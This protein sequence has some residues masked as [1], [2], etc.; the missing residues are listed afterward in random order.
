MKVAVNEIDVCLESDCAPFKPRLTCK[1]GEQEGIF[2]VTLNVAAK[3]ESLLP[4]L[5]LTWD[6]PSVDFHHKWNTRCMQNRALDVGLGSY[7]HIQSSAN[8]GTPVF[9]LYSLNGTN[10]CTWA[11]SDVIHDTHTGGDYRSGKTFCCDM[12]V[13]GSAVGIVKD[14]AITVRFDFRRIPYYQVLGDVSRY[15][16]SLSGC[17]PCPIP[18][19][20][21]KPLLSS[22]YVYEIRF[23]AEDFEKNCELAAKMGFE[24]AIMDDGWQ[25]SQ[26]T[27]GYQN[28]GDW[29]V[30]EEKVPDMVNHVKRIHA[31]GMKY[32][33]WFSVPFVGIESKAYHRFKDMLLPGRDGAQWFSFDMRFPEVRDYLVSRFVGF[34]EPRKIRYA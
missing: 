32:M 31:M 8:S 27:A 19:A 30:C 26:T 34:V 6:I 18:A 28:N 12:K 15:W 23:D 21:R 11:L 7:N 4:D 5:K 2:Y 20:A 25:T 29:E 22:W 3:E 13:I 9:S 17:K 33:V 14:Y 16:E 24:T 10:A 1:P